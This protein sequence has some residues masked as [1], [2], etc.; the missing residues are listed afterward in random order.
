MIAR[1]KVNKPG[2]KVS[3]TAQMFQA[4]ADRGEVGILVLDEN[5]II[6]FA[7]KMFS[8][9][10]GLKHKDLTGKKF[11][12]FL[13]GG[14]KKVFQSL[15][16]ES[17][18]CEEKIRKVIEISTEGSS[19]VVA[20]MCCASYVT[21]EG[22]HRTFV[23]LRDIAVQQKLTKELRQSEKRYRELFENIDQGISI[24]TR[25]GKFIDC[26]PAVLKILGYDSK[27]E[28][29]ML[30]ISKDLYVN[31]QDRK[32]FQRLIEKDGYVKNYEVTFKKK[33]GDTIP[34]L[35]T[36]QAIKNEK[37]D[38]IGYQGLNI[39]ISER[40]RMEQEL[41][42]K[43]GFLTNLLESSADCIIVS[44]MRGRVIFY[45]KAAER[46]TGYSTDEVIGKF[47]VTKFYSMD[48]AREIMKKLRSDE[49]GDRGKLE[50][51]MLTIFGKNNEEIPV[52]L[53]ASI[54]YEGEKELASLGIFTDLREKITMEKEL[55]DTQVR[56]LQSEK[57]AS[58]GSLAAGVAH[59]INNPLGGI[60]IYASLLMEDFEASGDP[61]VQDL[62]KIVDEASR[63]KEIVKSL[64][65]F[66]RQTE[67]RFEPI[68]VNKAI[69]DDLF[70]LEKQV[71]FH[72]IT[73]IKHL[74]QSL[75]SVEGDP[76]QI[77]QV[78]MN[79]MVN[80]AEAMSEGG[81][82][83]TITTGIT[84]D[85]SSIFISFHDEGTGIPSEIQS[86][87][88]DPFF[89]TK[90]VGKGTGLG[91]STSYGIIQSHHGNIDVESQPGKG[92]SFTIYLP[93]S[94]NTTA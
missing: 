59:E 40:I 14:N 34:I 84:S 3:E 39:D 77:K 61:R 50:N 57:M 4:I 17:F 80:A 54:V 71:L 83:L 75:P 38:V 56:L 58:L 63:C 21:Q 89:T 68:D 60:L 92:T 70:F 53:S 5:D 74:D 73:I 37:G 10:T 16:K 66:G 42:E 19:P 33:N 6:E 32:E 44:D 81:G 52:S 46:L 69:L 85:E 41:R 22:R 45:N 93:R 9:I 91:L 55:Q 72:D 65:E 64:L 88:F 62:K 79:M 2:E 87:I 31:P 90:G 47:H 25:E 49:Y 18:T 8:I 94:E 28:F 35:L 29:L 20:E 11:T 1:S 48:M 24:S 67:S 78:F 7:N 51:Y 12:D 13:V 23:Y 27:E 86:K 76:N 15:K 43:H 26:N 30:D 82:A 36:T